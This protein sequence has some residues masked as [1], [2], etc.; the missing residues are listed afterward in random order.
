MDQDGGFPTD[1]LGSSVDGTGQI[2]TYFYTAPEIEQGW[3]RID[4]KVNDKSIFDFT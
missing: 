1:I 4:E 2:G 3:P